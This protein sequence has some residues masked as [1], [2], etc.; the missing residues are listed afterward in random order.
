MRRGD[1]DMGEMNV[2]VSRRPGESGVDASG[3]SLGGRVHVKIAFF[4]LCW[5]LI[6]P[7]YRNCQ[8][9]LVGFTRLLTLLETL[10]DIL[11]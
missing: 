5:P 9:A 11:N 8:R 4:K 7:A 2:I 1:G 10:V 3:K 6:Y